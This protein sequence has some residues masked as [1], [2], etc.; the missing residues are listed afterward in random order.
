MPRQPRYRLA[1]VPQHVTQRGNNRQATFFNNADHRVYLECLQEA[2]D[3]YECD[4]HAYVLMTN[5]VHLLMTPGVGG[6]IA[7]VM[8]SVGRR[9]VQY[10]NWTYQRTGTLW[11]GRYKACPI[12]SERYLLTCYRY[13]ELNPVRAAMVD[14]PADY[15]WSSHRANAYGEE[16]AVVTAHTIYKELGATT[17]ERQQAYRALFQH[18]IDD[19]M[20]KEIRV[21]T[22]QC[23]VM[24]NDRFKEDIEKALKIK[25]SSGKRGRPKKVVKV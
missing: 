6:S 21:N 19:E 13:I 5:H 7:K 11:E 25:L 18:H 14:S 12:E 15:D 20:L 4:I 17:H 22:H 8:Q 23:T 24:G 2:A 10:I 9:Y 16:A 1:G 3:K